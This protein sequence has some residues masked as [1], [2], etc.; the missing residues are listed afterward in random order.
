MLIKAF[1]IGILKKKKKLATVL[2]AAILSIVKELR[3]TLILTSR[4]NKESL[5]KRC[6]MN[7]TFKIV[8][9]VVCKRNEKGIENPYMLYALRT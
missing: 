9:K 1:F 2:G 5:C 6:Q 7:I 4:A 3:R 8:G